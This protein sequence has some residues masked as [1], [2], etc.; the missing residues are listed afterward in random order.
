MYLYFLERGS[1]LGVKGERGREPEDTDEG[2]VV[3]L[4]SG[5]GSHRA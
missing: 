2:A 5:Q 3:A 4:E 1:L